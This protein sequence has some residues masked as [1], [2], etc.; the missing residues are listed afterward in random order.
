MGYRSKRRTHLHRRYKN[1]PWP[2]FK[3][4]PFEREMPKSACAAAAAVACRATARGGH[5]QRAALAAGGTVKKSP[6]RRRRPKPLA[7][8]PGLCI[9]RFP[10]CKR[11]SIEVPQSTERVARGHVARSAFLLGSRR[12]KSALSATGFSSAAN[13]FI[14]SFGAPFSVVSLGLERNAPLSG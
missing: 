6:P 14:L 4:R 11:G 10:A 9:R 5:F 3:H 13:C 8:D 7:L 12:S 1:R 2:V